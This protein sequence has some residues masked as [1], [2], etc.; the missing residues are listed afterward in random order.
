MTSATLNRS[1][2]PG[3][4]VTTLQPGTWTIDPDRAVVAF[5]GKRSFMTPTISARFLDVTG[6]VDVSQTA[7]G[8]DGAVDV[9]VDV[10]SMTTGNPVWDEVISSFDPFDASRFPVAVY[11]STG[12]R[13]SAGQATIDGSLTLRGVTKSLPLTA[14]YDVGRSG[15]R[16]LVRAAGSM[17]REAF[18]VRFDVPGCGKLV[19]RVMRLEIDVDVV[20]ATAR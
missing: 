13:W 6:S 11:R 9:S 16:M 7:Q 1:W 8:L 15:S 5:S 3:I 17:D 10:T 2:T 20:L 19:P 14:S 18:G 4:A 12:V